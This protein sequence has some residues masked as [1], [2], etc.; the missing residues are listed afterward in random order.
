MS[1][2]GRL[3]VQTQI[4]VK[5][6][7]LFSFFNILMVFSLNQAF[8]TVTNPDVCIKNKN[9]LQCLKCYPQLVL[10]ALPL[11]LFLSFI[12]TLTKSAYFRIDDIYSTAVLLPCSTEKMQVLLLIWIA[13]PH[14]CSNQMSIIFASANGFNGKFFLLTCM[15]GREN[16]GCCTT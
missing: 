7:F 13:R 11:T 12:I 10:F 4:Y 14:I 15:F 2:F 16:T 5:F 1:L 3:V 9:S 6:V 8:F